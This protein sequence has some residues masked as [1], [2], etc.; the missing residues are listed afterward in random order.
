V[1]VVIIIK[2]KSFFTGKKLRW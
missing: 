1:Q 2:I